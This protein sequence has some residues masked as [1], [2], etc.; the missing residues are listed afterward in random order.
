MAGTLYP[1]LWQYRLDAFIDSTNALQAS[2]ATVSAPPQ[3]RLVGQ[4]IGC[5]QTF[6][7]DMFT[8]F[9]THLQNGSPLDT[10]QHPADN[11][12][13]IILSQAFHDLEVLQRVAEQRLS[14]PSILLEGLRQ[15]DWLAANVVGRVVSSGLLPETQMITYYQKSSS[16]RVIPYTNLAL[17]GV[18]YSALDEPR[19]YLAIPHE[20]GHHV[21]WH[22]R[23]TPTAPPCGGASHLYYALADDGF[24]ALKN[25]INPIRR[26][27]AEWSYVW[28]EELF[29]DIFG[30]WMAG[31]A[32]ALT[33]QHV[34]RAHSDPEF[35]T[36][37]GDHPVPVLRPYIS[38]KALYARALQNPTVPTW[39]P[40]ASLL[41]TEW[42]VVAQR[43][44]TQFKVD[45]C[46]SVDLKAAIWS[47]L[48]LETDYPVDALIAA[49]VNRLSL[50]NLAPDDWRAPASLPPDLMVLND[51]ARTYMQEK[52]T[53]LREAGWPALSDLA[54]ASDFRTWALCHLDWPRRDATLTETNEDLALKD[55]LQNAGPPPSLVIPETAW[56][57]LIRAGGWTTEPAE[58]PWPHG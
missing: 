33:V 36:S 58:I 17:I 46:Q 50:F 24:L 31:P 56:L 6:V 44:A 4:A 25:L 30:C 40:I 48:T 11:V 53:A 14:S 12:Y 35:V 7:N 3:V 43:Y 5:L 8:F 42:N 10:D 28:L 45:H 34:M 32:V 23:A 29:A 27:F 9:F 39:D 52:A 21:F 51:Q 41:K 16:I 26:A 20:V 1:Q 13:S 22:G 37:D 15:A 2:Y 49:V 47:D 19:D 54:C 38:M 55:L 57:R 18:P